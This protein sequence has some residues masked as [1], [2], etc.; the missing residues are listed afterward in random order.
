MLELKEQ[1]KGHSM[2]INDQIRY[3]QLK[4]SLTEAI[5]KQS[6]QA[7]I[8]VAKVDLESKGLAGLIKLREH[9]L[10]N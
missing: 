9:R 5:P 6:K 8:V 4:Q 7:K 1:H 2:P 3:F 10:V